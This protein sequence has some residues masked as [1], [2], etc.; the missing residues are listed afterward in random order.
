MENLAGS[1]DTSTQDHGKEPTSG[2][3][4]E[5]PRGAPQIPMDTQ[6]HTKQMTLQEGPA[7]SPEDEGTPVRLKKELGLLEAITM[8]MGIVIGSGIFVSPKGVISYV[9][10]VGMS[11]GVWAACGLLSMLG[12]ICFAELGTMIPESGGM[13]AYLHAAFGPLPAFLYVWVTAVIRNNAGGAVVALTFAYYLLR[14]VLEE[15]EAVPE[16]AVRLVA[17]LLICF[18]SWVNCVN[19]KWAAKVQN[20]FTLSKVVALAVIIG[21]GAA[22]LAAGHTDNYRA[23]LHNT[24]WRASAIAAAFYQ[25]LFSYSGWNLPLAIICSTSLVTVIYTLTNAAYLAVLTPTEMISSSAVAVT[26]AGRTLGVMAWIMPAFV[27][28]STF[29]S[30]NGAIFTQS[31]LFFIGAR[32]GQFPEAFSLV[33]AHHLTPVPAIVLHGVGLLL[34]LITTDMVLLITYSTYAMT[35][36]NLGCMLALFWFRYKH[37][38]KPRP[39]KVWLVLPVVFSAIQVFLLV[40]PAI[41]NPLEVGVGLLLI[42]TGLPVYYFAIYRKDLTDKLSGLLR[43]LTIWSQLVFIGLPE[44]KT[45]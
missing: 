35:L 10:S 6:G 9:G 21:A 14:A 31:R 28:C 16:A 18:H 34:M 42:A 43:R 4:R 27:I 7:S 12:A 15:C 41:Q 30:T 25:S 11:L 24:N 8:I 22:H 36:T 37:P 32:K 2:E 45:A 13:Y 19:V 5:P 38:D 1:D 17:A 44:E 3:R 20:V 39:F 33:H 26:F 40:L 29:G 23:P